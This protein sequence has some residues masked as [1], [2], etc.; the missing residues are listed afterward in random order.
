MGE[1]SAA[2]EEPADDADRDQSRDRPAAA[3]ADE[4]DPDGADRGDADPDE[5]G[6]DHDDGADPDDAGGSS[7]DGGADSG[8]GDDLYDYK[9]YDPTAFDG[10]GGSED[11]SGSDG[12]DADPPGAG[13]EQ[14]GDGL[15]E[16]GGVPPEE[17]DGLP[18]DD[19]ET[20]DYYDSAADA[21]PIETYDE[22]DLEEAVAAQDLQGVGPSA[23]D[24]DEEMPLALHIEEMVRRLA[25]V[26][27]VVGIATAITFPFA[28]GLVNY[29]WNYHIP[30]APEIADRRPR[31]YGPLELLLTEIKVASLSGVVL[32][33]PVFVY[34]SYRFMRPGLYPNER[35]YYLASVP[36]SLLLALVG[37]AFAHFLVLPA[38][39][40]YFTY[41]TETTAIIAFGLQETFS[42]ILML[43]GF[44]AVVFQIPLFIM[45]A[46]MMNLVTRRWLEEKRLLFWGSF[47]GLSFLVSPDPTGMAPIIIAATMVVL[48]EGTLTLLRWT[49][50]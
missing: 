3:D 43:M 17:M 39:F 2:D 24:E 34:E 48:F 41:Y 36:T 25:V 13:S 42:L 21:E 27:A 10:V 18:D 5:A 11:D 35:R 6:D 8:V 46:I 20:V 50:N 49:G 7:D 37:V 38:I 32:G 23:P 4:T 47:L 40:A 33:L 19:Q 16:T 30:G 14:D 12:A 9:S 1:D 44:M 45:L 26:L 29:L 31:L 22:E 15:P 28:D